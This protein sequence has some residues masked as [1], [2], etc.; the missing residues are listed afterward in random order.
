MIPPPLCLCT[1]QCGLDLLSLSIHEHTR[2]YGSRR[3]SK[4]GTRG[5]TGGIAIDRRRLNQQVIVLNIERKCSDEKIVRASGN[6]ID[7]TSHGIGTPVEFCPFRF[8][9]STHFVLV[10]NEDDFFPSR[11]PVVFILGVAKVN[12]RNDFNKISLRIFEL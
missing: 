1:G 7:E 3:R 2:V 10:E 5:K 12:R 11:T 6:P 8:D 4:R 9:D